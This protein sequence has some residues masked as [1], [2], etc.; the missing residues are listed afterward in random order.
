M[1]FHFSRKVL[2]MN[3]L[4]SSQVRETHGREFATKKKWDQKHGHKHTKTVTVNQDEI[5]DYVFQNRRSYLDGNESDSSDDEEIAYSKKHPNGHLSL[6]HKV[7]HNNTDK[8]LYASN[9][10]LFNGH[11]A[12]FVGFYVPAGEDFETS[13][14][15][16]L[17]RTANMS[18]TQRKDETITKEAF[19]K[20]DWLKQYFEEESKAK[21]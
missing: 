12:R 21:N 3:N 11:N 16:T 2:Q 5:K 18:A 6:S 1:S 9:P 17:Q 20:T 7:H 8:H 13:N 4:Q 14:T 15:T 10:H 19:R